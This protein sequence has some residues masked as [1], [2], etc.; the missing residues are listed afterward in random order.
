MRRVFADTLYWVGIAL[1]Q[2]RWNRRAL[3]VYESLGDV[4]PVTTDSVIVEFLAALAGSGTYYRRQASAIARR[5][6]SEENSIVI[7]Q[8]REVLLAGLDLYERR[9]DKGYSLTD[10]ISMNACRAE[11]ITEILTN[12]HHFTQEGFSVL[13]SR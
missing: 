13:I 1:P 7:P 8:T 9:A 2:D 11:G 6:I 10:C 3:D 4:Q 5:I 12:D